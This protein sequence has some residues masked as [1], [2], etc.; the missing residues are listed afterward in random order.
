MFPAFLAGDEVRDRVRRDVE[1]NIESASSE[2]WAQLWRADL[3]VLD[4]RVDDAI[5]LLTKSVAARDVAVASAASL[6]LGQYY[7]FLGRDGDA[8]DAYRQALNISSDDLQRLR[9]QIN[10]ARVYNRRGQYGNV[11]ELAD[12][13]LGQLP[14]DLIQHWMA[15][16]GT[17]M[18]AMGRRDAAAE[19]FERVIKAFPARPE[20][21]LIRNHL[22][23]HTS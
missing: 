9:A 7:E 10:L 21:P 16:V 12:S 6:Y 5:G 19:F 2:E 11:V 3:F 1:R 8:E 20:L 13:P 15:E 22:M 18:L 23:G 14:P 17:A 4:G